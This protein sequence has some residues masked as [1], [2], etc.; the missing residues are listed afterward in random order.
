MF[1]PLIPPGERNTKAMKLRAV[2]KKRRKQ[3]RK[4]VCTQ[5][6]TCESRYPLLLPQLGCCFQN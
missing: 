2:S 5:T 6:P 3:R 4:P 1:L